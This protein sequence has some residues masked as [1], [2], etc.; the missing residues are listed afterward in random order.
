MTNSL[1]E[2]LSAVYPSLKLSSFFFFYGEGT[3]G[4]KTFNL[5][6]A[7][8]PASP[9]LT[10]TCVCL[11]DRTAGCMGTLGGQAAEEGRSVWPQGWC[12]PLHL[13]VLSLCVW[14][15]L[16]LPNEVMGARNHPSTS[17]FSALRRMDIRAAWN[18]GWQTE[19][20]R[21]HERTQA[22]FLSVRT[23]YCA[24]SQILSWEEGRGEKEGEREQRL[25]PPLTPPYTVGA[26]PHLV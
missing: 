23:S 7:S 26:S 19:L 9:E 16:A 3:A 10:C 5:M 2:S 17:T 21:G 25:P 22:N 13:A 12:H 18:I 11:N 15:G 6:S 4:L 1:L 20:F 14:R 8:Q 24:S